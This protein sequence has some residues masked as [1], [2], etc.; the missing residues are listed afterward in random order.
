M[1]PDVIHV[2]CTIIAYAIKSCLGCIDFVAPGVQMFVDYSAF[3]VACATAQPLAGS[4]M[5]VQASSVF[6][7]NLIKILFGYFDPENMFLDN[8]NE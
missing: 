2:L 1:L 3:E 7:S 6:F 5:D 8:K 4:S